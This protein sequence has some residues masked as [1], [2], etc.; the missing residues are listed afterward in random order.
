M[1]QSIDCNVNCETFEQHISFEEWCMNIAWMNLCISYL[2]CHVLCF[3]WSE[4]IATESPLTT[5]EKRQLMLVS[6]V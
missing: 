5:D 6:V 1:V 2:S 3:V 4:E